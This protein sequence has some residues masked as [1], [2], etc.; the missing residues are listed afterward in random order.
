MPQ[1]QTARAVLPETRKTACRNRSGARSGRRC[2]MPFM[3]QFFHDHQ[4]QIILQI[5]FIRR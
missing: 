2:C 1:A 3:L 4:L 5:N